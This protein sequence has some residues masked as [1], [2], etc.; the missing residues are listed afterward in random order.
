MS[1]MKSAKAG[2]KIE[3]AETGSQVSTET[4]TRKNPKASKSI[5]KKSPT[6]VNYLYPRYKGV[7]ATKKPTATSAPHGS[8]GMKRPVANESTY[9]KTKGEKQ[10]RDKQELTRIKKLF[11]NQE[12]THPKKSSADNRLPVY[13]DISKP[14]KP[15]AEISHPT[16]LDTTLD[17]GPSPDSKQYKDNRRDRLNTMYRQT[18]SPGKY[19]SF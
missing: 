5:N 11:A 12:L 2:T 8:G 13:S 9:S 17:N 10:L 3:S 19:T 1:K 4:S 6:K 14:S 15:Y 7:K 18:F 16:S